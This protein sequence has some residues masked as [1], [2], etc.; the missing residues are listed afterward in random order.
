MKD[1]LYAFLVDGILEEKQEVNIRFGMDRSTP[2]AANGEKRKRFRDGPVSPHLMDDLVDLRA[3]GGL[4]QS[5]F[6]G[7]E[8]YLFQVVNVGFELG[9]ADHQYTPPAMVPRSR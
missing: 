4:D 3:N 8:K 1:D 2:I 7:L 9:T 6:R 5:R